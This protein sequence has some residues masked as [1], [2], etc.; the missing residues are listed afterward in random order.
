VS[1]AEAYNV[2][3]Q[4]DKAKAALAKA[5]SLNAKEKD[6]AVT[7][8]IAFVDSTF[9]KQERKAANTAKILN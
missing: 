5:K 2:G 8:R 1:L 7:E 9:K 6:Q 4:N 3:K